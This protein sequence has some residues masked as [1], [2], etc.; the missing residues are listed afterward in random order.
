M[1]SSSTT[2][3][4]ESAGV[5]TPGTSTGQGRATLEPEDVARPRVRRNRNHLSGR[6]SVLGGPDGNEKMAPQ[7][8][9]E[10]IRLRA[11][12][13]RL[14][15]TRRYGGPAIARR[16]SASTRRRATA[17]NPPSEV[18]V[19]DIRPNREGN[20]ARI[21]SSGRTRTYPPSRRVRASGPNTALRRTR[22]SSPSICIHEEASDG[23]QP[24]VRGSS[25]G[26]QAKPRGKCSEDWL[27]R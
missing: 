24:P 3:Q 16:A 22:H 19:R 18:R 14:G 23:G 9:L 25:P 6:S 12:F 7:V 8:G 26:Y 21:G 11:A 17:G 13:A 1:A 10:P 5:S 20:A 4:A 27:L 2:M 15:R